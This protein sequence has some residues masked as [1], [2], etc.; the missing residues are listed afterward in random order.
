MVGAVPGAGFSTSP[1]T[2]GPFG[3]RLQRDDAE[4]VRLFRQAFLQRDDVAAMACVNVDQAL[5]AGLVVDH[6]HVGQQHREGLVADDVARRPDRMAEAARFLLAH[7]GDGAD[8]GRR[9]GQRLGDRV[10]AIAA[11]RCVDL[12]GVVEMILDRRLHAAGHDD[13]VLDAGIECL[14]DDVVEHRAVDDG[15]QFL[16]NALGGRKHAGAET[17]GGNDGLA[18]FCLTWMTLSSREQAWSGSGQ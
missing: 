3:G 2:S 8:A 16:G 6:Q 12:E 7:E 4:F 10:L 5:E 14:G 17:G 11:Q 1:L 13:H 9:L 15:Q 18:D